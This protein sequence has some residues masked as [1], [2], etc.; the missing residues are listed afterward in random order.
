[1][2]KSTL[3]ALKSEIKME[4]GSADKAGSSLK[5][6][7]K[8]VSNAM[9]DRVGNSARESLDGI[10]NAFS[11]N[12]DQLFKGASNAVSALERGYGKLDSLVAQGQ[13]HLSQAKSIVREIGEL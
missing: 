8:S 11:Y 1:M 13:K 3:S 7:E 6:L 9:D 2:S 4:A 12:A 10:Y 5:G